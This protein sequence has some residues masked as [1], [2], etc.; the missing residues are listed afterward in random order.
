MTRH[1]VADEMMD[2][3][4]KKTTLKAL[5]QLLIVHIVLSLLACQ[6]IDQCFKLWA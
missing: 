5:S 2:I 1:P 3:I 4:L 6:Q